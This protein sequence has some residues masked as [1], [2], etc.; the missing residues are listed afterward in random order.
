MTVQ[1]RKA[2]SNTLDYHEAL[3]M[4]IW[5]MKHAHYH[6][7]WP[8]WNVDNDIFPA[9]IHGQSKLYFDNEQ[10]PLG[11]VTWAWLDDKSRDQV[12]ANE[13]PLEV[14]QWN[15]GKHLMFA[16]FIAPWG[17]AKDIL[18]DLRVRVFPEYRAFS[19]GRYRDGRIRKIYYWKG[20]RSKDVIAD[21]QRTMNKKLWA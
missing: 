6:C 4:M 7:Q 13:S 3:G 9:L 21:E 11:F 18:S 15:S 2:I 20:I 12:L 14:D 5:L 17:H 10:S 19:L 16:D 1:Q 8:L